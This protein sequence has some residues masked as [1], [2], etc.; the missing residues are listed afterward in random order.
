MRGQPALRAGLSALALAALAACAGDDDS[1][2]AERQELA[3]TPPWRAMHKV[4]GPRLVGTFQQFCLEG[5]DDAES[6][7]AR[8]RAAG[9]VPAGGW[10]DGMR[11]FVTNDTRPAVRLSREGRNCAVLARANPGQNAAI[12]T[13]IGKWFPQ[14]AQL[15]DTGLTQIWQTGSKPGEGIAVARTGLGPNSNEIMLALIQL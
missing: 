12:H 11:D 14:A 5:A 10:R 15:Q 1:S 9:F 2:F 7:M 4:T 3:N 13:A 6:R 8:L